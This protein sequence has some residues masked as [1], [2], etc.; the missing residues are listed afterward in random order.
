MNDGPAALPVRV[1]PLPILPPAGTQSQPCKTVG[2]TLGPRLRAD[3]RSMEA[4]IYR[5]MIHAETLR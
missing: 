1:G 2:L 4:P 5:F 3:E